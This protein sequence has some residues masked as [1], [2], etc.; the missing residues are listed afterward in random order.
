MNP[1]KFKF[2]TEVQTNDI[3]TIITKNYSN[4]MTGFLELQIGWLARAYSVFKDLDKYL[5]LMSLV[6]KTFKSYSEYLINYSYGEFYSVNQY[7]LKKFNIVHIA[8][9]LSISK[10]TARRKILEMEKQGLIIK[11]KKAIIMQRHGYNMQKP[12]ESITQISRFMSSISKLLKEN[13]IVNNEI[14]TNDFEILIKKNFTQCWGYF[15]SFQIEYLTEFKKKFFDDYE[16]ISIWGM[17]VY[18]QNIHFKKEIY[19]HDSSSIK[20]KYLKIMISTE[21]ALGLNAMTIS[22]LT[23]IPRPTVLRKLNKLVKEKWVIKDKKGLYKMSP[24]EKN[25]KDLNEVRL[26]NIIKISNTVAKFYNTARFY[27]N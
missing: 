24:H 27:N 16:T 5:I 7:E 26:A 6:D 14:R 10:E 11:N 22:D 13:K 20:E 3:S 21:N 17:I 1:V 12:T 19:K 4:V 2:S 9:E 15:L 25:Y 18:N 23:G 8:K